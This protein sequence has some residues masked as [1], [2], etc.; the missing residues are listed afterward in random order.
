[1]YTLLMNITLV[2]LREVSEGEKIKFILLEDGRLLYGTCKWHKDLGESGNIGSCKVV[3]A[4]VIPSHIPTADDE[5]W[6]N[7]QSTGYEVITPTDL[8]E[9][10]KEALSSAF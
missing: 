2:N 5:D 1:M 6:G 9:S 10:I 4:G 8:R 3:G 7:W